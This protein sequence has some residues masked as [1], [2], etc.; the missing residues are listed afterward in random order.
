MLLVD[1][2]VSMRAPIII[3]LNALMPYGSTRKCV[4]CIFQKYLCSLD[5]RY[6]YD[7]K[8]PEYVMSCMTKSRQ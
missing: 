7:F 3:S 2:E 5:Y 8:S 4:Y 6:G 1:E